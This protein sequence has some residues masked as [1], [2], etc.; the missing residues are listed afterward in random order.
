MA[1]RLERRQRAFL[2]RLEDGLR[3]IGAACRVG[4]KQRQAADRGVDRA[5][6]AVVEPHRCEIVGGNAGHGR[7]GRGIDELLSA[8]LDVDF[9]GVCVEKAGRPAVRR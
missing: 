5:A 2:A 6:Q 8:V 3:G 7:A 1:R 9:L 4:G